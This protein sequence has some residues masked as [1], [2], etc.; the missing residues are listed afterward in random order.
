[1]VK[2]V[3]AKIATFKL[4]S[5]DEGFEAAIA[6]YGSNCLALF[7]FIPFWARMAKLCAF[8]ELCVDR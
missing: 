6:T 2:K 4:D 8:N 5:L 7:S 3:A 1:M